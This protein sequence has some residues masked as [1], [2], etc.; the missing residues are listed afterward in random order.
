MVMNKFWF[1]RIAVV[2]LAAIISVLASCKKYEGY[3]GNSTCTGK[4]KVR[5]YS[6]D[7]SI[8]KESHYV[9]NRY[10]YIIFGDEISYGDRVKTNYDGTFEFSNLKAGNYIVY[11]YSA[12]TL[13]NTSEYIPILKTFSLTNKELLNIGD[14]VIADNNPKG[15]G[16]IT[17]RVMMNDIVNDTLYYKPDKKV[18]II[19]DN[20]TQYRKYIRTNYNGEFQFT[21][22]PIGHYSIYCYSK[23]IN[24]ISPNQ[25]IPVI[26]E[27][28]ITTSTQNIVLPDLN[29]Y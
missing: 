21:K 20:E 9:P 24:N 4:L 10:V 12:D 7:F 25:D 13:K 15:A 2:F 8:F 1:N 18:Y 28:D 3:G 19:Y 29:I 5:V 22:L 16:T 14:L 6:R 17:G 11:A 27:T 23:D 26:E